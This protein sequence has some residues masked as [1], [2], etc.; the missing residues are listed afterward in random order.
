[1]KGGVFVATETS[2]KMNPRH[3]ANIAEY[4]TH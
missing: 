1:M 4:F 2:K 3:S